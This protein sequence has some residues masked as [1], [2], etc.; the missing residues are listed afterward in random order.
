MGTDKDVVHA[1]VYSMWVVGSG[2]AGVSSI[3][4]RP[5]VEEGVLYL[6]SVGCKS[7]EEVFATNIASLSIPCGMCTS[8]CIRCRYAHRFVH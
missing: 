1:G 3:F 4:L 5:M 8:F 6:Q 7:V 2:E